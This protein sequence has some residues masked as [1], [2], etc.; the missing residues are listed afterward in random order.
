MTSWDYQLGFI[1][2]NRNNV[3]RQRYFHFHKRNVLKREAVIKNYLE[4]ACISCAE[5]KKLLY[6]AAV[7]LTL[8]LTCNVIGRAYNYIYAKL[9][10]CLNVFGVVY[11]CYGLFYLIEPFCKLA[12]NKVILVTSC[13]GN[14]AVSIG[15]SRLFNHVYTGVK[16]DVKRALEVE[17]INKLLNEVPLKRLPEDLV[18]CR[19]WANLMFQ[20]RGMPFVDLAFL[21]KSDLKGNTLSYRRH[22]TGGQMIVDIPPTAMELIRQYQNTDCN[23]PY[24]FPILSGTKTGEELYIE[25]QQALR[26][27]NYNLGRLARRC[28]VITKVSSYTTRHTWATLAKYCNFSEQLICEAFGHSSVKVTETYLKNFK[29]EEIK[30]ANDAII[31]Y[32]S[33]NGKKRA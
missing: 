2:D 14:N 8:K 16:N 32:V 15:N 9:L 27:M 13:H 10:Q 24:L 30:K 5:R 28:G 22:K 12:G 19:V 18:R 3:E 11:L 20:L 31:L 25:Y 23:S 21:H 1:A 17:E 26:I 33:K 6:L 7:Y 29:Y 4:N